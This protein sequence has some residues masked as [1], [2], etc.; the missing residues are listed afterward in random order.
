[1]P[2]RGA[3]N[4]AGSC[5]RCAC[6]SPDDT[7]VG[8]ESSGSTAVTTFQFIRTSSPL[9]GTLSDGGV[10][11]RWLCASTLAQHLFER[12]WTPMLLEQVAKGLFAQLLNIGHAVAREPVQRREGCGVKADAPADA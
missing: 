10:V 12:R 6:M 5:V 1:M 7:P 8:S 4:G 11:V 2:G 9:R 3:P